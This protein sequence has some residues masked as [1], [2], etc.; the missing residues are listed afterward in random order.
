MRRAVI[1]LV[2]SIIV[3]VTAV[4]AAGWTILNRPAAGNPG[5]GTLIVS[6]GTAIPAGICEEKGLSGKVTIFHSPEC[7]A[8]RQTVPILNGIENET[9]RDF[10]YIDVTA[11]AGKERMKELGIAPTHIPAVVIR[12]SVYVGYRSKGEFMA[13]I[14]G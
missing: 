7:P 11:A 4:T 5:N 2:V 13:L 12:C 9:G 1:F 6:D 10:E 14:G 3:A 8:C